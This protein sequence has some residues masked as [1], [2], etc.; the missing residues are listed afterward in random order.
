MTDVKL[1][2]FLAAIA[3]ATAGCGSARVG[4]PQSSATKPEAPD[5]NYPATTLA[6]P[7]SARR[8]DPG[9]SITPIAITDPCP[10]SAA[11]SNFSTSTADDM[12]A[13]SGRLEP[14]MGIVQQYGAEHPDSYVSFRLDWSAASSVRVIAVFHTEI[15]KHRAALKA[16][17][18]FP[19]DL[20]VCQAPL[21][22]SALLEVLAR[23]DA[24][25]AG[26]ATDWGLAESAVI[27]GLWPNQ[28]AYAKE[29]H[30]TYG[31][32]VRLTV[33]RFPYP[34]PSPLPAAS[35]DTTT[36]TVTDPGFAVRYTD[37]SG[38]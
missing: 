8:P 35:C 10:S 29:L 30:E 27:V 22:K 24:E 38:W 2:R 34:M 18:P 1:H 12:M 23:I 4:S 28:T 25:Q 37:N 33:G 9:V 15:E 26:R 16:L 32:A 21:N 6:S 20:I 17:V 19:Q 36:A 3:L 13:E 31:D 14:M 7:I 11:P 5:A